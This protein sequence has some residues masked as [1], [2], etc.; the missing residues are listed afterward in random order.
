MNT[1]A[2]GRMLRWGALVVFVALPL[3]AAAF[4]VLNVVR[5]GETE[6]LVAQQE[7]LLTQ[8]EAR[9]ARVGV[10][11]G[12]GLGDTS[13]IYLPAASAPLAGAVLQQRLVAAVEAVGGRVIETQAIDKIEPDDEDDVRLRI[14]LDVDNEGLRSLMHDLETGLPLVTLVTVSVRQLPAQGNEPGDNP[15]LRVDLGVRGFWRAAI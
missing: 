12:G 14:T 4:T 9:L 11:E 5:L 8:L 15:M 1:E 6:E 2:S 7:R 3:L 13:A 10:V